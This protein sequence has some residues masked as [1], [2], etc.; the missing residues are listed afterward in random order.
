[1]NKSTLNNYYSLNYC[2]ISF[3]AHKVYT[4]LSNFQED[5]MFKIILHKIARKT[6]ILIRTWALLMLMTL[7][8]FVLLGATAISQNL[9]SRTPTSNM[10]A[11]VAT[12]SSQFFIDLLALEI[13]QMKSK[14]ETSSFTVKNAT[15]FLFELITN[16]N[17]SDPKSLVAREIPGLEKDRT[18]LLYGSKTFSNDYPLDIPPT[19]VLEAIPQK[20][21]ITS[22]SK[23]KLPPTT[24]K[25]SAISK[26]TVFIYHSHNRESWLPE[27]IKVTDP[28]L[29]YD[30]EKNIT[31]LGERM[32]QRLQELGIG[33]IHSTIDYPSTIRDFKYSKSYVYSKKNRGNSIR[34]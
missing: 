4:R 21:P 3:F 19:A 11:S 33:T 17:P 1:M 9:L 5:K 24:Q 32:K 12:V 16:T 6:T 14:Q 28:D 18:T 25:Q 7:F 26:D 30:P 10:K 23:D 2:S 29:A 22:E 13:P 15:H 31:L 20:Y 27:L 8:L 34:Q